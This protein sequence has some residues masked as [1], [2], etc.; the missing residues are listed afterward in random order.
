MSESLDAACGR[1][2]QLI[3][4]Q[5]LRSAGLGRSTSQEDPDADDSANANAVGDGAQ[6]LFVQALS[7]ALERAGGIG[8]RRALDASLGAARK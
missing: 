3:L 6:Q 4:A 7:G 2:E 1:F 5:M 8:L